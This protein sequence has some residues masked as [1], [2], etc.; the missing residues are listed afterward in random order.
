M[1]KCMSRILFTVIC[2]GLTGCA[3]LTAQAPLRVRAESIFLDIV[4]ENLRPGSL[5]PSDHALTGIVRALTDN[6]FNVA[7]NEEF[8]RR[9]YE[10][11][12][13]RDPE[14]GDFFKRCLDHHTIRPPGERTRY[15]PWVHIHENELVEIGQPDPRLPSVQVIISWKPG[16][17]YAVKRGPSSRGVSHQIDFPTCQITVRDQ[18]GTVRSRTYAAKPGA[19]YRGVYEAHSE[20]GAQIG[21]WIKRTIVAPDNSPAQ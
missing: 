9:E 19:V 11:K 17:A 7:I 4:Y 2:L 3:S 21:E 16:P 18:T 20:A 12:R 14:V 8:V 5:D 6:G 10:R 15:L 1:R 13:T